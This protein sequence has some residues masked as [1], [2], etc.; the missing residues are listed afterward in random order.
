MGHGP[1]RSGPDPL[2]LGTQERLSTVRH[3][4]LKEKTGATWLPQGVLLASM[5]L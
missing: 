1:M 4:H 5:T 2:S 3:Y